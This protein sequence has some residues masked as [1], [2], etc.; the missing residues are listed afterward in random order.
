MNAV[1]HYQ[2]EAAAA[3]DADVRRFFEELAAWE[4]GHYD[5]LNRE[6]VSVREAYWDANGFAPH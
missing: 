5:A 3:P 2:A 6:L 1:R 4:S